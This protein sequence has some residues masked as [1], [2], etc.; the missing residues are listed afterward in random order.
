MAMATNTISGAVR[1]PSLSI[2]ALSRSTGCNV[3]TIRYYERIGVM[4]QPVRSDGGHRQYAPDQVRR[5]AFIRR[6][7][8]LG[9]SLQTVRTL[10]S[11]VD[12]GERSCAD[13]QSVTLAHLDETRRKIADLLKIERVLAEMAAECAGGTVPDCPIIEALFEDAPRSAKPVR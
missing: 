10:L 3:E 9:F 4:P 12:G 2:G 11:F 6:S 8:A 7:R 13:V 5:L 1:E